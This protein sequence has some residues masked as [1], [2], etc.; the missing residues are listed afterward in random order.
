M[1]YVK[2][3]VRK[4]LARFKRYGPEGR[5]HLREFMKRHGRALISSSGSTPGI[6]QLTPPHSQGVRGAKAKL[7]GETAVSVDINRVYGSPSKL[8]DLIARSAGL[9][10]AKGFFAAVK[11]KDWAAANAIASRSTGRRLEPFD[12]GIAHQRRRNQRGRV[13][14]RAPSIYIAQISGGDPNKAG[15]WV[16]AYIKNVQ[17][18]VGL[19]AA[20]LIPSAEARLGQLAGVPAWVRRWVGSAAG[21][22]NTNFYEHANGISVTASVDSPRAPADMQRRMNRATQYRMNAME[23]DLPRTARRMEKEL[24]RGL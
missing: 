22:G 23:S 1:V 16:R 21:A 11:R 4:E 5:V 19:L 3:D 24:Q 12:D 8:F 18:R 10:A 17:R 2:V 13:N 7:Q 20:A 15:P 9:G 6:V 14:G